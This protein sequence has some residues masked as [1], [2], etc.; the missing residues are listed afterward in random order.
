MDKNIKDKKG[1]ATLLFIKTSDE[2]TMKLLNEEG[3]EMV[4]Y[5]GGFWTFLNCPKKTEKLSFESSKFVFSN[6]LCI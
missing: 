2:D 1:K 5:S 3:F 4:D 6:K